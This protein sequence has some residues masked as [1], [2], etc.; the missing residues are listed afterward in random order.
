M[1]GTSTTISITQGMY[2]NITVP[3]DSEIGQ[4]EFARETVDKVRLNNEDR[5]HKMG[6]V[7]E[8]EKIGTV[9]EITDV[10]TITVKYTHL[11]SAPN[12]IFF[13]TPNDEVHIISIISMPIHDHSSIYQGGPAYGSYA[14]D[15]FED[16]EEEEG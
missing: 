5:N 9:E 7:S 6:F 8:F 16:P 14:Y 15:K 11:Q 2:L 1:S 3:V 12:R 10:S 13:F 4:G